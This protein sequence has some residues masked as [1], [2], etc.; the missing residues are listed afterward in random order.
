MR[1]T[2]IDNEKGGLSLQVSGSSDTQKVVASDINIFGES[3]ALDC[4]DKE[5]RA[6]CRCKDKYGFMLASAV[7]SSKP[8][9]PIK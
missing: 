6:E 2:F 5:N 7:E 9:H 1:E 4:P 8:L 3:E